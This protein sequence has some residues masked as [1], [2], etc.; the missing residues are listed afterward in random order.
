MLHFQQ[1]SVEALIAVIRIERDAADTLVERDAICR[2]GVIKIE[3]GR[4]VPRLAP[5]VS[6]RSHPLVTQV[7]FS[8]QGVVVI[9]R[10]RPSGI[11]CS[12]V[13]PT[14]GGKIVSSKCQ[15]GV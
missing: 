3:V 14:G 15:N 10:S 12:Q 2:S 8:H 6:R 1:Q 4:Q 13:Y 11:E 5:L 7:V 9:V